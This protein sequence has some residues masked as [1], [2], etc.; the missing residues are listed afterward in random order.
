MITVHKLLVKDGL[1]WAAL[2]SEAE[3]A[4]AVRFRLQA[5]HDRFVAGRGAMRWFVGQA[6]GSDPASLMFGEGPHG[7]PYVVAE[8]RV[9]FNVSHSGEWVLLALAA[10]H[11]VG[12]DVERVRADLDVMEIAPTV[13]TPDETASLLALADDA[14]RESFYRLW[15]RKEAVL[16][17]WGTG[18]SLDP[19]D[20]HIGIEP[21]GDLLIQ[22]PLG[23]YPAATVRD[24]A[25]DGAHAAAVATTD[26]DASIA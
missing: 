13:F 23:V 7:K 8:R 14:R 19:R 10:Q 2:L 16:K 4:R 24:V 9:H 22:A 5:D 11:E 17:A 12:V 1:R 15:A 18:F 6:L 21:L 20:V 26:A 25:V 3:R